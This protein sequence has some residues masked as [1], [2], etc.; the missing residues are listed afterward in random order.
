MPFV[1]VK[2]GFRCLHVNA[3]LNVIF[4]S[5][6]RKNSFCFQNFLEDICRFWVVETHVAGR[7]QAL[8]AQ[9]LEAPTASEAMCMLPV[10]QLPFK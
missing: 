4:Y 9:G 8:L 1:H 10:T 3:A 2:C 5:I 6:K 7:L